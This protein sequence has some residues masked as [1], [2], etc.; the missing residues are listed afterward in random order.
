[1]TRKLLLGAVLALG[2]GCSGMNNTES[3]MLGG[4][5]I[6]GLLGAGVGALAHAPV[7]GAAIGAATG[8][9]VGGLAGADADRQENNAKIQAAAAAN[10]AQQAQARAPSLPDIVQMTRNGVPEPNIIAQIRNSGVVY[11]LT[12]DDITY[13]SQNGVS[14]AVIMELQSRAPGRV[15]GGPPAVIYGGP[16]YVY[17]Y[18]PP[19]VAVGVGVVGYRRW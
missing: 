17:G 18:P 19:P 6:G 15:Y 11:N 10:A 9:A 2:C 8:A 16:G 12:P 7:A 4:G 1:M 3:G 13:L 5:A 14:S